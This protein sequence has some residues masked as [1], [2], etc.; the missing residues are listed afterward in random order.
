MT[1]RIIILG[2]DSYIY[3]ERERT[4]GLVKTLGTDDYNNIIYYIYNIKTCKICPKHSQ[5]YVFFFFK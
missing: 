5:G 4:P 3:I 1:G 2:L